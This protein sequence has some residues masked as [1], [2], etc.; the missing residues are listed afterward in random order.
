MAVREKIAN[1]LINKGVRL[2]ALNRNEEEIV[3]YDEV[4]CRF[5]HAP[6]AALRE[7]VARALYYKGLTLTDLDRRVEANSVYTNL[8]QRFGTDET[9]PIR[10]LVEKARANLK[11]PEADSAS[12]T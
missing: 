6:Q 11:P 7:Q 5:G 1:A 12:A 9:K 10:D 3:I 8:V 4:V 2:G